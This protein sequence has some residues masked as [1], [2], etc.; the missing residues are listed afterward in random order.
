MTVPTNTLQTPSRTDI[1][2]DLVNFVYNVD[3]YRTPL[4]NMAKKSTAT[5]VFHEWD[6]DNL[7]AQVSGNAAI[8][9]DNPTN[10]ALTATARVGNYTQISTK[11]LQLSGTVQAVVAAGGTNK[12]GYQLAKKTK[13]LKRDMEGDLTRNSHRVAPAAG[14]AGISGGL[15]TWLQQNVIVGATGAVTTGVTAIG[16]ANFGNGTANYTPGTAFSVTE[17]NVKTVA[18]EIYSSSGESP[19][20]ALVSPKNKQNISA[21][22][23]PGTRFIEVQ[24][25]VLRTKVD[26]YET[27]FGDVKLIPDIFMASSG[28]MFFINPNFVKV[29]YLRPFQ[30]LN[31]AK[32]GDSDQKELLCEYVLEV[33]NEHA[34][35]AILDTNG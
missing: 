34:H 13:E 19:E 31:L 29:A 16:S 7:A 4:L 1:R 15:P 35:G 12:M 6:I 14:T 23:G 25:A 27:D 5:N 26:V 2:E 30:T 32:T 8:Q 33:C 10:I 20:Y 17:A 3:P 28:Y 22:A 9:G 24:D 21:F 18:Q 11:T